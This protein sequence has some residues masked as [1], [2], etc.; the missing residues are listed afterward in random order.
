MPRN[1][2][3]GEAKL[4]A[5]KPNFRA[6]YTDDANSQQ[7]LASGETPVQDVLSMNAYY[8]IGQGIPITLSIPKEGGVLGVDA[9]AIMSGSKHVDLD[10]KFI[11][12]LY[13]PGVQAEIADAEEGK[14]RRSQRS[15]SI[16]PSPNFQAFLLP[17]PSGSSKSSSIQSCAPRSFPNGANGLLRT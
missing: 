5:L 1:W 10:H 6:Y 9:V 3:A 13:D 12:V 7:L 8:M 14:P 15:S 11:N 17:R 2:Q 16:Q 4:K